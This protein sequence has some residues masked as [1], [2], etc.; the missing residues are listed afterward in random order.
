M[1]DRRQEIWCSAM[2]T[3]LVVAAS[4][5]DVIGRGESLPWDIPEDLRHFKKLTAGHPVILGRVTFDSILK[6]LGRPLPN[7]MSIVISSSS[8]EQADN[9]L[10]A[11]SLES[12]ISIARELEARGAGTEVFV[13]GGASVYRQA[14]PFVDKIYLTRV[15][16]EIAG[17]ARMPSDW[18]QGYALTARADFPGPGSDC[19]CSFLEYKQ[20]TP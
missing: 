9:V 8:G 17:D 1:V 3:S 13:A 12:G 2:I 18:L 5:N 20:E 4:R 11:A 16:R 19:I 10:W 7:R 14:L 6:R 15:H